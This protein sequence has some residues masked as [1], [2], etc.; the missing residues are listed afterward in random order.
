M[1]LCSAVSQRMAERGVLS[2]QTAPKTLPE[3]E[4]GLKRRLTFQLGELKPSSKRRPT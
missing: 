4:L 3:F 1:T 2:N